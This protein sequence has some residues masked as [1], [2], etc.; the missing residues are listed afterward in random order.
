[1]ELPLQNFL[2]G[3]QKGIFFYEDMGIWLSLS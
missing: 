1:M 2:F 3:R